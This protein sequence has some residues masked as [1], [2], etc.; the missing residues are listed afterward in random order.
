MSYTI[1][2]PSGFT[3]TRRQVRQDIGTTLGDMLLLTA[4]AN[5]STT[6]FIDALN[7]PLPNNEY[8]GCRL[9]FTSSPNDNLQATVTASTQSSGTLTFAP[10]RSSTV[11]GNT[12]ELWNWQGNGFQPDHINRFIGQA[13]REAMQYLPVPAHA[14]ESDAFDGNDPTI[15]VPATFRA[16]TGVQ[17]QD[18]DLNWRS[19][20]RAK[21]PGKPGYWVERA[22][23]EIQVMGAAR[24][25]MDGRIYRVRGY[26][27]ES[28]LDDDTDTTAV[29]AEWLRAR[30]CELAC[31]A[32]VQRAANP[33]LLRDKIA[34]YKGDAQV[35]RAMVVG[36]R[37]ANVD[38]VG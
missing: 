3:T 4:T 7:L 2:T 9:Y 15:D 8:R 37:E 13:H 20:P 14:E 1:T 31:T 5:G 17:W 32:I 19:I 23:R 28:D 30:V 26:L 22:S 24:D 27:M 12:A 18:D 33:A 6:T 11:A 38:R 16:V 36:R 34:L 25:V 29:N 21:G 35:K 10:A